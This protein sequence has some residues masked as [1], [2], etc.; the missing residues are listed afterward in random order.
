MSPVR[1]PGENSQQENRISG[2]AKANA[3]I[4]TR[5]ARAAEHREARG[6]AAGGDHVLRVTLGVGH[7]HLD[8][9]ARTAGTL[10]EA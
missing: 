5:K 7:I 10:G 3:L 4:R 6:S 9:V 1:S 2:L 8:V